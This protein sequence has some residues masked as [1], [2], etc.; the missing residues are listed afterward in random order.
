MK[1]LAVLLFGYSLSITPA[2]SA[3]QE[4]ALDLPT[5]PPVD[6]TP[7]DL[8]IVGNIAV[9]NLPKLAFRLPRSFLTMHMGWHGCMGIQLESSSPDPI[10]PLCDAFRDVEFVEVWK[11]ER[12][13]DTFA[14]P[15]GFWGK[16][17]YRDKAISRVQKL[18]R[19]DDQLESFRLVVD[20][21]SHGEDEM[22]S[23][24]EF[25]EEP[26]LDRWINTLNFTPDL[27]FTFVA[28][29]PARVEFDLVAGQVLLITASD[30]G[31]Y[32]IDRSALQ[33]LVDYSIK[34]GKIS[35]QSPE[36]TTT[37]VTPPLR[38][39]ARQP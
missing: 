19:H 37:A 12:S 23:E 35:N 11:L 4:P 27:V 26:T 36:P 38:Q 33:R 15:R 22:A 3:A 6:F 8:P 18:N 14:F 32:S 5:M 10:P 13:V 16:F 31:F 34:I 30:W 20:T 17:I 24:I 9:P 7:K 21:L 25:P 29:R 2:L 28:S 39:E 1:A